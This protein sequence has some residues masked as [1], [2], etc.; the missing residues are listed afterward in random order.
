MLNAY[1]NESLSSWGGSKFGSQSGILK[2]MQ[3]SS[4]LC[5]K[6]FQLNQLLR[7]CNVVIYQHNEFKLKATLA[8]RM[9]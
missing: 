9:N 3:L 4:N 6:Y 7:S 8:L 5:Q 1:V 2:S